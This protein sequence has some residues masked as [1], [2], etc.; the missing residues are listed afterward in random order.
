M[1]GLKVRAIVALAT[2]A[3]LALVVGEFGFHRTP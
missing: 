3:H 1:T 2:L